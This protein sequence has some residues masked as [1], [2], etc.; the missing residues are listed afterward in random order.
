MNNPGKAL[1]L[2]LAA[3]VVAVAVFFSETGLT[4][5]LQLFSFLPRDS[6]AELVSATVETQ[7]MPHSGDSADDPA[8]WIHPTRPE[9]ST[10]IGTDKKGGLAVHD[11]AG[12]QIQYLPDGA[13]NNADIRSSF[14][15]A[16]RPV[17][18]VTAGNRADNSIA[19]YRINPQ[20]GQLEDVAARKI[21]T[22]ETYGSCNNSFVKTFRIVE[23]K[24]VDAVE[25]TDGIDVTTSNLG[26]A[27]PYGVF[28]AQDGRND[29]G[30]QNFKLVL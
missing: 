2:L 30:N 8:I 26:P 13:M 9:M 27:F 19:I 15:L 28:V 14:T 20:S 3:S 6:S 17:D 5:S 4:R 21:T 11:L 12:N 24:G 16:G 23:G 1:I 22:L 18:L 29:R 7:P 25:E 10:V